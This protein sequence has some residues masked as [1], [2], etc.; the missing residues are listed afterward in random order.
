MVLEWQNNLSV[1]LWV[2]RAN[3]FTIAKRLAHNPT[4]SGV[5]RQKARGGEVGQRSERLQ[6]HRPVQDGLWRVA[7]AFGPVSGLALAHKQFRRWAH[8]C[9]CVRRHNQTFQWT[10]Y[11]PR[12]SGHLL[13]T[14]EV[15]NARIRTTKENV[16]VHEGV[17]N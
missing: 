4:A 16:E 1:L 15:A 5:L 17:Q 6:N 12:F 14:Q 10:R 8:P 9:G 11:F 2:V 13:K 7:V 3:S